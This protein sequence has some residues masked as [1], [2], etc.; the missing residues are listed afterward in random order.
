LEVITN[1]RVRTAIFLMS[2]TFLLLNLANS[3][4]GPRSFGVKK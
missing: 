3:S 4:L 2:V 1:N